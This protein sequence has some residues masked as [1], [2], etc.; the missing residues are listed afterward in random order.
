[1]GRE[2][3]CDHYRDALDLTHPPPE[4][5]QTCSTCTSLYRNPP[6]PSSRP[7][8][9][10]I[11]H[12][13]GKRTVR[14]LLE[15]L[16][17]LRVVVLARFLPR[18]TAGSQ[19]SVQYEY[20]IAQPGHRNIYKTEL[21]NSGISVE[22]PSVTGLHVHKMHY[23]LTNLT[24]PSAENSPN[25]HHSQ[26]SMKTQHLFIFPQLGAVRPCPAEQLVYG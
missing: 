13:V 16:L 2:V 7:W 6:P 21:H 14:I 24:T 12:T 19:V 3:P 8:S 5:V 20:H 9:A 22:F 10:P 11:R 4:C 17:V 25:L 23:C 18:S 15:C 26:H 1:M